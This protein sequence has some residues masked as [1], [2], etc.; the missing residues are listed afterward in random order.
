MS[1]FFPATVKVVC[2]YLVYYNLNYC[3][4]VEYM[5]QFQVGGNR[6]FRTINGWLLRIFVFLAGL[7]DCLY[8]VMVT[9]SDRIFRYLCR[10]EIPRFIKRYIARVIDIIIFSVFLIFITLCFEFFDVIAI[11]NVRLTGSR[12]I[13][14]FMEVSAYAVV[15]RDFYVNDAGMGVAYL[16]LNALIKFL[17]YSTIYGFLNCRMSDKLSSR[18]CGIVEFNASEIECDMRSDSIADIVVKTLKHIVKI[19]V[20]FVASC[21]YWFIGFGS[22]PITIGIWLFMTCVF[23]VG[24]IAGIVNV[25]ITNSIVSILPINSIVGLLVDTL[26]TLVVVKVMQVFVIEKLIINVLFR[27]RADVIYQHANAAGVK[28][29]ADVN[30]RQN[31][32]RDHDVVYP[33][34]AARVEQDEEKREAKRRSQQNTAYNTRSQY[35]E[36]ARHNHI[37]GALQEIDRLAED[38]IST[39]SSEGDNDDTT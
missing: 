11:G 23:S 26:I 7:G 10:L 21:C 39:L 12:I 25:D 37:E 33:D 16:F 22:I 36:T 18:I 29:Y 28:A 24:I 3:A 1:V 38:A 5:Q 17:F 31:Y 14:G 30:D 6:P 13:D 35:T 34:V 19:M 20:E 15:L 32:A 8:K 2:V 4:A 9:L 27:R